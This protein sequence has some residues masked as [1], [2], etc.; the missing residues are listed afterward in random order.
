MAQEL[1]ELL[2]LPQAALEQR[3]AK[4]GTTSEVVLATP[5]PV[6]HFNRLQFEQARAEAEKQKA[7]LAEHDDDT[8]E[9]TV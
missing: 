6:A 9:F 7:S 2:G 8:K 4:L 5:N 3:L 1:H